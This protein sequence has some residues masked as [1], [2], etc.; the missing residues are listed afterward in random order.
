MKERSRD[1]QVHGVSFNVSKL[2]RHLK[3]HSNSR[4]CPNKK[5]KCSEKLHT[6]LGIVKPNSCASSK[7]RNSTIDDGQ[8]NRNQDLG[9]SIA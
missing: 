6:T 7:L 2:P 5:T 3:G 4:M 8:G 9:V 1:L